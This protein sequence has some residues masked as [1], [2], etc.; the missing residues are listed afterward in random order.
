MLAVHCVTGHP[1][2][3]ISCIRYLLT[4]CQDV[5]TV[6]IINLFLPGF[7]PISETTSNSVNCEQEGKHWG[8]T[9]MRISP[10]VVQLGQEIIKYIII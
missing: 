1:A 6:A 7:L 8:F 3:S 9:M 2:S 10:L 4:V 5:P